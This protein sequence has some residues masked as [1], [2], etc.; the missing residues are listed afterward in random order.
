MPPERDVHDLEAAANP[1]NGSPELFRGG[2][3][4]EIQAVALGVELESGRRGRLAVARGVHVPAA[5]EKQAVE[6]AGVGVAGAHDDDLFGQG[7]RREQGAAVGLVRLVRVGC[8]DD[9]HWRKR[10]F[11][12]GGAARGARGA[13]IKRT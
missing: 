3:E 13:I 11:G 6:R 5:R 4:S 1:E 8:D 2:K 12:A 10:A 7:S 9:L